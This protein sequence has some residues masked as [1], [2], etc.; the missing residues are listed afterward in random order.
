MR[1]HALARSINQPLIWL[2]YGCVYLVGIGSCGNLLYS[3]RTQG[4]NG[5]YDWMGLTRI[6]AALLF[7]IIGGLISALCNLLPLLGIFEDIV[8]AYWQSR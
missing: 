7:G 2:L 5:A 6:M 8:L 1:V 3:G 4:L